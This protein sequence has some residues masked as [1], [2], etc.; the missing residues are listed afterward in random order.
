[1][2]SFFLEMEAGLRR[3]LVSI[4]TDTDSLVLELNTAQKIEK[5]VTNTRRNS[6]TGWLM[7]IE[8]AMET[9]D[10]SLDVCLE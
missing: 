3:G 1:M 9:A 8:T 10:W 6:G 2:P 7:L 4:K 5:A